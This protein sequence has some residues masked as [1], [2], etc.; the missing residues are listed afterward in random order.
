MI[1]IEA[2]WKKHDKMLIDYYEEKAKSG[3]EQ[4]IQEEELQKKI[5]EVQEYFGYWVDP[6]DPRFEFMLKEKDENAK[7]VFFIFFRIKINIK[8][9]RRQ[10]WRDKRRRRKSSKSSIR[11][12]NRKN[13]LILI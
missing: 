3:D 9:L 13:K 12:S 11:I 2:N 6:K 7:L 1:K 5:R 10:N 4:K 8:T